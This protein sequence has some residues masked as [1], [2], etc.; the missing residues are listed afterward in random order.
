[1]FKMVPYLLFALLLTA[2]AGT[3]SLR[4]KFG[5]DYIACMNDDMDACYTF[6]KSQRTGS[7]DELSQAALTAWQFAC[8]NGHQP[9]CAEIGTIYQ[10]TGYDIDLELQNETLLAACDAGEAEACM[11]YGDSIPELRARPFYERACEGDVGRGCTSLASVIRRTAHFRGNLP[12]AAKLEIKGCELGD[13]K[14][15]L[16]AGQA[17][18]FGSGVE[19]SRET[20]DVYFAKAC[21]ESEGA[22]CK[23]IGKIHQDGLGVEA[24]MN[25]ANTYYNLAEQHKTISRKQTRRSAYLLFVNACSFGDPLGCFNAGFF[26]AQGVEVPRNISTSRELFQQA[27]DDG[28]DAACKKW[29]DVEPSSGKRVT[30]ERS[31]T[32]IR[33]LD[34]DGNPIEKP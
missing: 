8:L 12:A 21:N 13:A 4:E 30:T 9:S 25:A 2:C 27:C 29:K 14:G 1:M 23:S 28:V 32:L 11:S 15:C 16:N 19:A 5:D 20:A 22:G 17:Y 33:E 26:N 6:A 18:L 24:D 31:K 10:T 7:Q 3:P 34:R